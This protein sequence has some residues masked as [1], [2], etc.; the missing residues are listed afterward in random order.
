MLGGRPMRLIAESV[1]EP[2]HY[3]ALAGMVR[4]YPAFPV[5]AKRYFIGGSY[6]YTC[7]IRTPTGTVA[8][9]VYSHHDIFT[10]HEVFGRED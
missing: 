1:F 4:L 8:P 6:P 10:V 7:R 9:I 2:Q 5:V 3:R